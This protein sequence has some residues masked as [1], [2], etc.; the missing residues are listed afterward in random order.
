MRLDS[1]IGRK[2]ILVKRGDKA[3]IYILDVQYHAT[4]K[5][6]VHVSGWFGYDRSSTFSGEFNTGGYAS[7]EDVTEVENKALVDYVLSNI[8]KNLH[9]LVGYYCGKIGSDPEIFAENKDGALIPAFDFLTSKDKPGFVSQPNGDSNNIYWDGYQAEFDTIASDCMGWHADSIQNGLKGV[10]MFL[11]KH[12]PD[13]KLSLK[14]TFDIPAERLSTD[15]DEHVSFGCMPS[16]NAY[17]LSGLKADGRAVGFRSAGGHIHFGVQKHIQENHVNIVKMLDKVLGVAC[18]SMFAKYDDPRRRTMYG[19]PGEYRLPA[20]GIEY[21]T[22]SNAWLSHPLIANIIFDLARQVFAFASSSIADKWVATEEETI[23]CITYCDVDKAREI[24][25]RNE[26]IFLAL[27]NS[28]YYHE[29][30]AKV[31]RDIFLHGMETAV[32]N[33]EDIAGNWRLKGTWLTHS[34]KQDLANL[35]PII[36]KG[37][38]VA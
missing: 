19:L 38:K 12:D 2:N 34:N 20:H 15:K 35:Y 18:V 33:P 10:L 17:G 13:A 4:S 21:R 31:A 16:L 23:E 24:L 37:N 36:G 22:L 28:R 6:Y 32:V 30:K 27:I 1:F 26:N 14:T 7:I 9:R 29:A 3:Y 8:E 11:N 25:K 5:A